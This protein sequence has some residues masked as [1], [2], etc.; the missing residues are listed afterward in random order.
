[1]IITIEPWDILLKTIPFGDPA[2]C[3]DKKSKTNNITEIN[4][5]GSARAMNCNTSFFL[6]KMKK[7][8][9]KTIERRK[10]KTK[11]EK[12][13]KKEKTNAQKSGEKYFLPSSIISMNI[14]SSP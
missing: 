3:L 7:K 6:F 2:Q 12:K 5:G 10:E 1:M 4:E 9:R 8:K 13:R 14:K 11:K